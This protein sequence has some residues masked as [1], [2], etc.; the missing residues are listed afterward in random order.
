MLDEDL[1]EQQK[2]KDQDEFETPSLYIFKYEG[3][4]RQ[5]IFT[6]I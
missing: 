6:I 1:I 3:S 2:Q 4:I 5:F